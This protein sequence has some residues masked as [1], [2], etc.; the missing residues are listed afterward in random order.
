MKETEATRF[1]VIQR[2]P[3]IYLDTNHLINITKV[4]IGQAPQ[5]SDGQENYR[6]IDEYLK[7]YCALIFN[8]YAALEWV[9][10]NA[11]IE[12]AREI[13]AV[14]DS[15]KLKYMLEVDYLV[16]TLEVLAQCRK[17]DPNINVPDL[18]I[19]QKLSDKESFFS[20]LGYMVVPHDIGKAFLRSRA[21]KADSEIFLRVSCQS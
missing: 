13:A 12:S 5:P 7:S 11:T 2:P 15:A 21:S 14:V 4:R 18:P 1:D 16:Y 3:K 19:L 8:P 6:R 9:E 10:R 17:Q 20:V